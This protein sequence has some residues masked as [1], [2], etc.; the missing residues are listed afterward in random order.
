MSAA[1][2]ADPTLAT[3]SLREVFAMDRIDRVT[4]AISLCLAIGA[5]AAFA[6]SVFAAE[7]PDRPQPPVI[8]SELELAPP[9]PPLPP[10]ST[11]EPEASPPTARL[12]PAAQAPASPPP[13]ARAGA[14]M[15]ATPE[16]APKGQAKDMLDFVTDPAGT[17]YGSGVVARGGI[18]E[19]GVEGAR[20]AP[21]T[22]AHI[23]RAAP[24][25]AAGG[26]AITPAASLAKTA[27]LAGDDPCHG[28]FPRETDEDSGV[29]LVKVVVRPDGTVLRTTLLRETPPHQGFGR[30]AERCLS[31]SRFSAALDKTGRA[32]TAE[33]AIS[34]RFVR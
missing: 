24:P 34:V 31:A 5:H 6:M 23:D 11:P 27:S 19:H 15:T 33:V 3:S 28:F 32:V 13:A 25:S 29:A 16:E 21:L 26:D 18:A 12:A 7:R 1:T 4:T 14:L 30:A 20:V 17:S 9:P 10:P 22:T 2:S 8:R